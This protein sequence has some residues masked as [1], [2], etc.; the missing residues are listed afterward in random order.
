MVLC[1]TIQ[2]ISYTFYLK[3]KKMESEMKNEMEKTR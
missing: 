2:I 3:K 1:K